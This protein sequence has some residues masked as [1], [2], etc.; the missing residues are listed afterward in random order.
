MRSN[1]ENVE[2]A[3]VRMVE[4][5]GTQSTND[6]PNDTAGPALLKHTPRTN[7]TQLTY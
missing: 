5:G 4:L 6:V 7:P 1:Q 3:L 2:Y